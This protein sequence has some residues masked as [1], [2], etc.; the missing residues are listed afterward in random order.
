MAVMQSRDN[1]T[2][3]AGSDLSAGQ[4]KFL[5]LASDGQVDVNTTLG[6]K[7]IGVLLNNPSA[8][9]YAATVCLSGSVLVKCAS[10]IA[11]GAQ[12]ASTATGLAALTATGQIILGYALEAGVVN[13][14]IEIEFI[15]G[16]NAAA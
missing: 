16:G 9:G 10:T 6:G 12:V 4:F 3:E 1:R 5:A 2:F 7:S 11:A 13:Q 15:T 14:I 8:V